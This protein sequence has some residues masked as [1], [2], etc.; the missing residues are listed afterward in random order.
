MVCGP[1]GNDAPIL[2]P[3]IRRSQLSHVGVGESDV[4]ETVGVCVAVATPPVDNPAPV[5]LERAQNLSP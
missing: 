3:P 1:R 5:D 4:I 2:Q